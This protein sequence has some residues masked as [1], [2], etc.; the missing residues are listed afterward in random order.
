M[1]AK[2]IGR[3]VLEI[4]TARGII[5]VFRVLYRLGNLVKFRSLSIV[6]AKRKSR[7]Y[8]ISMHVN[9]SDE[10]VFVKFFSDQ[11]SQDYELF[12]YSEISH[13]ELGERGR[14]FT[15]DVI[16]SS[17]NLI[18][19]RKF[20]GESLL[21]IFQSQA[22]GITHEALF[23]DVHRILGDWLGQLHAL[24]VTDGLLRNRLKSE[25][26]FRFVNNACMADG[27]EKVGH[28]GLVHGDFSFHQVIVNSHPLS[29]YICDFEDFYFGFTVTDLATYVSKLRLWS[30]QFIPLPARVRFEETCISAFTEAYSTHITLSS[31][32]LATM[33]RLEAL[34]QS[35][36]EMNTAGFSTTE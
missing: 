8:T 19:F 9:L 2:V 15:P 23:Y 5:C 22:S 17:D 6:Q 1:F 25:S 26:K 13:M 36:I 28:R 18:F 14:V 20:D 4:W 30:D 34:F 10:S 24:Q 11:E 3:L 35:R 7:G 27:F 12:L 21:N 32:D 31:E 29:I 16:F 33:N